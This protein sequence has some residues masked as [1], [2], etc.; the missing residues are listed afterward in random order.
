MMGNQEKTITIEE[1]EKVIDKDPYEHFM[2]RTALGV[3]TS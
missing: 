3:E 1:L 2:R